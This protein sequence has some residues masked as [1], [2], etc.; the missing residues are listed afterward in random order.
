VPDKQEQR[1][2]GRDACAASHSCGTT[3][4][5]TTYEKWRWSVC[6]GLATLAESVD[7]APLSE[8]PTGLR[9][10]QPV[11]PNLGLTIPLKRSQRIPIQNRTINELIVREQKRTQLSY[12]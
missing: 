2:A 7:G 11:L 3:R 8:S 9:P 12:L 1:A 4:C 6:F 5:Y 10:C